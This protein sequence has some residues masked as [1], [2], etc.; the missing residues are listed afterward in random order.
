MTPNFIVNLHLFLPE[1]WFDKLST[2]LEHVVLIAKHLPKVFGILSTYDS[3]TL[4]LSTKESIYE[5]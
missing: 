2:S 1:K 5:R 3:I 4:P